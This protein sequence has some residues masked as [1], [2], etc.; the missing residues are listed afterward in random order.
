MDQ[1]RPCRRGFPLGKIDPS[2]PPRCSPQ[3]GTAESQLKAHACDGRCRH[4]PRTPP[5]CT[6]RIPQPSRITD[7]PCLCSQASWE[8][9]VNPITHRSYPVNAGTSIRSS[10]LADVASTPA[11]TTVHVA[12][13]RLT[14]SLYP[15][16]GQES[17]RR[18]RWWTSRT[19]LPPSAV[20]THC[21]RLEM[22]AL[23]LTFQPRRCPT[24]K[25]RLPPAK[26]QQPYN[27]AKQAAAPGRTRN[28]LHVLG[29]GDHFTFLVGPGGFWSPL[30]SV[31]VLVP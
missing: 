10:A 26:A 18:W 14:M 25:R 19:C 29:R 12:S 4:F 6:G 8:L 13:R 2:P 11:C 28:R 17:P 31:V 27:R 23:N 24:T 21:P 7:S 9:H 1:R 15:L 30:S 3:S 5:N 16:R 20:R 22:P